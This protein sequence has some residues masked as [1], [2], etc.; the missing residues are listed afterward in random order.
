MKIMEY[1]TIYQFLLLNIFLEYA[2]V[3]LTVNDTNIALLPN[4]YRIK[5]APK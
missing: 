3:S 2:I 5:I 4:K 1:I